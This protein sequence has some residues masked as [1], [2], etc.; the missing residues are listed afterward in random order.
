MRS[1]KRRLSE[2]F[3]AAAR[4]FA[5]AIA[6]GAWALGA[7]VAADAAPSGTPIR[8]GATL[9]LTGPLAATGFVH[10]LAGDIFVE[11]INKGNGLLGRPSNGC[12]STTSPDPI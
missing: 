5:T 4:S 8:V 7:P 11:Q 6:V 10:K 9:A 3:F 12:C 1:S 2:G